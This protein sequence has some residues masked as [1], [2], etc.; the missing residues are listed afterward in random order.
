MTGND[1]TIKLIQFS[2]QNAVLG[3]MPWIDWFER[4]EKYISIAN[5]RLILGNIQSILMVSAFVLRLSSRSAIDTLS[6]SQNK[7]ASI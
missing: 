2:N 6:P 1:F 5:N 3:Y 7:F 4:H